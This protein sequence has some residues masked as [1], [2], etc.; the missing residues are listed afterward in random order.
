[1]V[2]KENDA[3]KWGYRGEGTVNLVLSHNGHYPHFVVDHMPQPLS[4]VGE[5][6]FL[7]QMSRFL[8]LPLSMVK[9]PFPENDLENALFMQMFRLPAE[10]WLS[11]SN[12][13]LTNLQTLSYITFGS[14][15]RRVFEVKANL[16]K[17]GIRESEEEC[18]TAEQI[19]G[20]LKKLVLLAHLEIFKGFFI[21]P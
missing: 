21:K 3:E 20:K 18:L 16:K 7:S 2:F 9:N 11:R 10:I 6:S 1:M 15:T 12:V 19:S 5:Y 13:A 8:I 17:L 14:I 4:I